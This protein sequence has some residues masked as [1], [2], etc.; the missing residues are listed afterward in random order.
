[1]S[2]S[3]TV[4]GKV[5]VGFAVSVSASGFTSRV[6][7]EDSYHF[8]SP[9]TVAPVDGDTL[10]PDLAGKSIFVGPEIPFDWDCFQTLTEVSDR[11][12]IVF[13]LHYR[14]QVEAPYNRD[15]DTYL[16]KRSGADEFIKN[17]VHT[18]FHLYVPEKGCSFTDCALH[19]F[20]GS[21]YPLITNVE[22]VARTADEIRASAMPGLK[23]S[24]PSGISPEAYALIQV[25]A[26]NADGSIRDTVSS[27][28]FLEEVNGYLP[29]RRVDLVNGVGQFRVGALG[30]VSG[31]TVRVKAGFRFYTGLADITLP[32]GEV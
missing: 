1:M 17:R 16:S 23:L 13:P 15:L 8:G 29:K 12:C 30:L 24:G 27:T 11:A 18:A 9:G 4:T 21:D 5:G 19:A 25:V 6:Y 31:D 20:I 2:I 22:M 3:Y 14:G 32:V 7:S 28:V 10:H 26:T